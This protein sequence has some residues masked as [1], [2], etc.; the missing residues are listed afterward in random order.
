MPGRRL[1]ARNGHTRRRRSL[2]AIRIIS[3]H[4]LVVLNNGFTY[5]RYKTIDMCANLGV[6][7]LS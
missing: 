3:F 2:P 5:S 7:D 1:P 6:H 4:N